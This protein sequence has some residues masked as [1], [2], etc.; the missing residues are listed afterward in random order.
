MR[1]GEKNYRST[2]LEPTDCLC[3]G[4]P[5]KNYGKWGVGVSGTEERLL[6]RA[7][8]LPQTDTTALL[9]GHRPR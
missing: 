6:S 8:L 9:P 4:C 5:A 7:L 2:I 1:R 3:F